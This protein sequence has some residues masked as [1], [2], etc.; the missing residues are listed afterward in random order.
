[1]GRDSV[2][3]SPSKVIKPYF[4]TFDYTMIDRPCSSA[5]IDCTGITQV[6]SD[7]APEKAR[8]SAG[9]SAFPFSLNMQVTPSYQFLYRCARSGGRTNTMLT[10][11]PLH[12]ER[13]CSFPS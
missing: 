3:G 1:M 7:R 13:Y 6:A 9:N 4:S 5:M 11:F 10:E 2:L 12:F 8:V